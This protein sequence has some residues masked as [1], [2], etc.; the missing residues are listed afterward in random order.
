MISASGVPAFLGSVHPD[1]EAELIES[2]DGVAGALHP[3]TGAES[4]NR[5]E[6][7]FRK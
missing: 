6:R 7:A 3:R 4:R 5:T 1:K 2:G